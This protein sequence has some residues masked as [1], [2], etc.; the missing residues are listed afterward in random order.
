MDAA[1]NGTESVLAALTTLRTWVVSDR[2]PGAAWFA[3]A[4]ALMP[5]LYTLQQVLDVLQALVRVAR[6]GAV[7]VTVASV[8]L[9][10]TELALRTLEDRY[11]SGGDG[12]EWAR[13]VAPTRALLSD[14]RVLMGL[15]VLITITRTLSAFFAA[16]SGSTKPS[17][18][19]D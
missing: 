16:R 12:N 17:T 18:R 15:T 4:L 5:V 14:P 8:L 13:Y 19:A 9:G 7:G 2:V 11:G 1:L 3:T 6:E 10:C